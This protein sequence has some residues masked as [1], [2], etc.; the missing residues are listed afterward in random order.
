M[1]E[2]R[3]VGDRGTTLAELTVAM[4]VFGIFGTFLATMVLQSNR[5]TTESA[6]RAS[7]AQTASVVMAQ[8]T[9][10]LRTAL[11]IGPVTAEQVAFGCA[12]PPAAAC[13]TPTDVVFFSSVPDG[14]KR[15]RLHLAAGAL[16]REVMLPDDGT[17]YP[18][19]TFT[20][21]DATRTTTRKLG[22]GLATTA[23]F[24]YLLRDSPTVQSSVAA[25]QLKDIA[26]VG[27]TLSV[28]ADGAG[29]VPPVVLTTTV[30]PYNLTTGTP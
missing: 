17:Q 13:A 2:R 15:E 16:H 12:P 10:D 19:V 23:T 21:T 26:A 18:N 14:P 5:L 4:L 9:R 25:G 30:R 24:S 7:A 28:D 22:A 6:S 11:R 20:S 1:G 8:V 3:P 29:R 27:V